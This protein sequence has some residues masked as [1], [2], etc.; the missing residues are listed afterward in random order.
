VGFETMKKSK[1]LAKDG[2][3]NAKHSLARNIAREENPRMC[4]NDDDD[5]KTIGK[6]KPQN[7]VNKNKS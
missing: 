4:N 6:K 7:K 1:L 2:R 5:I 3:W